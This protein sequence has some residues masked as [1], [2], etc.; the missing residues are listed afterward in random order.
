MKHTY[1]YSWYKQKNASKNGADIIVDRDGI[2]WF[3][4]KH[5]E[6]DLDHKHLR[7]TTVKYISDHRKLLDTSLDRY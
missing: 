3:N 4:E 6:E 7:G 5:I 1:K 2:L